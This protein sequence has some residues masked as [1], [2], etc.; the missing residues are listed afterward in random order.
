[1]R[2]N[3]LQWLEDTMPD[4]TSAIVLTHN[5]DFL[6]LQSIVLPRLRSVGFPKLTIFVDAMCASAAFSQQ[7]RLL[8][9]IGRQCRIV[10]V[11]MGVGRRF[12]PKAIF[13]SGSAKAALAIGSGNLT[14]GGWSANHE[15]W[16]TFETDQDD[17]GQ[18][19]A[20]RQYLSIIKEQVIEDTFLEDELSAAFDPET[21]V[22]A[23]TLA[24]AGGLIG[25][26]NDQSML[27]RM[28][29]AIEDTGNGITL[30][31][32]Y[33]DPDGEALSTIAS[34]WPVPVQVLM[35]G[36]A[37]G[38]SSVAASAQP[39]NVSI[40]PVVTDPPRF[41]H[42][43]A[44]FFE[45]TN[46]TV[47]I[48]GSANISRAALLSDAA[49]GNAEL[50]AVSRLTSEAR[51][52]LLKDLILQDGEIDFLAD[53]PSD[54]W[55]IEEASVKIR[56]AKHLDGVLTV[57]MVLK[58]VVK[59]IIVILNDGTEKAVTEATDAGTFSISVSKAPK[60]ISVIVNYEDGRTE[61]TT[62]AWVIDEEALGESVPERRINAK[63]SANLEGGSLSAKGMIEIMALLRDH[64]RTPVHMGRVSEASPRAS[65]DDIQRSYDVNDVF[66]DDFGALT[67]RAEASTMFGFSEAD[68]LRAFSAYFSIKPGDEDPDPNAATEAVIDMDPSDGVDP[69][70]IAEDASEAHKTRQDQ[71]RKR[72]EDAARLR[73]QLVN[74][75]DLVAEAFASDAFIDG[76]PT[77]R[78][79]A[80]IRATALLLRKGL[81]DEIL[82][83]E[84]FIAATSKLWRI[85]FFGN[86]D[87][88]SVIQQL[89]E[90]E[91]AE[92]DDLIDNVIASPSL[93]AALV[94]WS[95]P[96][97]D[98]RDTD[99]SAFRFSAML[100]ASEFPLLIAGGDPDE[101]T[102]ELNRL[103]R[104]MGSELGHEALRQVWLIWLRAGKAFSTLKETAS[105]IAAK[106]LAAKISRQTIHSGELLWQSGDLYVAENDVKRTSVSKAIVQS[107]RGG[108]DRRF[109]GN[110]LVPV[111]D[112]LTE[113]N[114][115]GLPV[116]IMEELRFF[117]PG[118]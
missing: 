35:Q 33:F 83:R 18:F 43:K 32:P 39:S 107:L 80:D 58:E 29:A 74:A 27:D 19:E 98:Q 11:D 15:I 24:P 96:N 87:A 56:S 84:D 91:A 41:I 47:L 38:L 68:F 34:R 50:L 44:Y 90:R 93:S 46:G 82:Y 13:L 92:G 70:L 42:A 78:I 7:H 113:E 112:L 10:S 81:D 64:A 61:T 66:S 2:R 14:H 105:Q 116:F 52:D 117:F 77:E 57:S 21:K 49:W 71:K 79:S 103:S 86:K 99:C 75:I 28:A 26:P 48:S 85:L 9:G 63:I 54:E 55:E 101:I 104:A 23:Q 37:P 108:S 73:K 3:V 8:S 31:S 6:F 111:A 36:N 115:L 88:P 97:W 110:F 1:M 69:E 94:L 72:S 16:S 40:V 106:D 51:N 4:A 89:S 76:R 5:I 65:A 102:H 62:P 22:W 20:F 59:R 17:G 114:P 12:H 67:G 53:A 109:S 45:G 25:S 118:N 60:S 95:A 100:L 30:I